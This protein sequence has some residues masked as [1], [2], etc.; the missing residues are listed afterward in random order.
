MEQLPDLETL[1]PDAEAVWN[2][3]RAALMIL[4]GLLAARLIRAGSDRVVGGL[5]L[6]NYAGLVRQVGAGAVVAVAVI[7]ALQQLGFDLTALLGAAGILSVALGFAS[8]TSAS[9]I[10]SGFFLATERSFG[11]G[12]VIEV[13]ALVGEV[14]S[15]DLLSVK[16][17]T[18]ENTFVRLPNEALI[19][20][21]ITNL[22][23]FPIRRADLRF[24][25]PYGED[26]GRI[27]ALLREIAEVEPLA[28]VEPPPVF[29]VIASGEAGVEIQFS[30][31]ASTPSY[32][33]ARTQVQ[34]AARAGLEAAGVGAPWPRRVTLSAPP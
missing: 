4:G 31:W 20:G 17:R 22:T 2:L 30:V 26:L 28:M 5:G 33:E 15:I 1:L 7:A 34:V 3:A 13:D 18:F 32:V 14:L 19:K 29:Q 6:G 8:Q 11:V 12:D 10:I 24:T 16:L 21:R 25:I 27:E 9:N 23:R